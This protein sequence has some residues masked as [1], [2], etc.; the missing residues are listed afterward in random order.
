MLRFDTN[1]AQFKANK[2]IINKYYN[3]VEL[4]NS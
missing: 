4:T 3:P 2:L 1:L